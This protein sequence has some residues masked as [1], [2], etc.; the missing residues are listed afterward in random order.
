M[1][2]TL[3]CGTFQC[4]GHSQVI[5]YLIIDL[6]S[7]RWLICMTTKLHTGNVCF[8][9]RPQAMAFLKKLTAR[10]I[11]RFCANLHL[12][13]PGFKKFVATTKMQFFWE[14]KRNP[15]DLFGQSLLTY[16]H[17]WERLGELSNSPAHIF[18]YFLKLF[19]YT[20]PQVENVRR[21]TC[22][23]FEHLRTSL[24]QSSLNLN[25]CSEA[26]GSRAAKWKSPS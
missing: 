3:Q 22:Y 2:D 6:P 18:L 24:N 21:K 14:K 10:I 12:T 4:Q 26:L 9:S 23:S 20:V 7:K 17:S 13:P 25:A 15:F 5:K 19:I 1:K 8:P 16:I 11:P